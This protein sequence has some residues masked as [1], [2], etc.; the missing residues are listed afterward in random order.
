MSKY[1]R[2]IYR[3][4]NKKK[5][6]FVLECEECSRNVLLQKKFKHSLETTKKKKIEMRISIIHHVN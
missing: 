3:P 6:V 4:F 2:Y 5:A 1:N